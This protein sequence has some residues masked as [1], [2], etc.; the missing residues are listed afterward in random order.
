MQINKPLCILCWLVSLPL[1]LAL[2]AL[3]ARGQEQLPA[4]LTVASIEVRPAAVELK[5]RFDYRQ[6]LVTGKLSSGESG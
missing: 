5:H 2:L 1:A 3:T 4:G 6:L